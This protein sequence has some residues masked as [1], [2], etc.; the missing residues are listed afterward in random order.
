MHTD[1]TWYLAIVEF[2][3]GQWAAAGLHADE[4]RTIGIQYGPD[5]PGYALPGALI[6]LHRG[7]FGVARQL[8]QQAMSMAGEQVLPSHQAILAVSELWTGNLDSALDQFLD[9]ERKADVRGFDEPFFRWWRAD[10]VEGLLQAGRIDAA[11]ALVADWEAVAARVG[12]ERVLAHAIRCR[13]L[14][15]AARGDLVDAAALLEEAVDRQ[16]TADDPFGRGRVLLALGVVRRRTRQKRTARAAL[17]AALAQFESLGAAS[18]AMT[19]RAELARVGGRERIEGLSPSELRV[20]ELVAEGR[21]NRE[22]ASALFLGERTVASHLTHIYAKLGIRSRTEL[23][24][25]MLPSAD[26]SHGPG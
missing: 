14:I 12:R 10:Y 20:A 13:G 22:I 4:A 25:E 9:A 5:Q 8:S 3:S 23:A 15:A 26:P 2:W 11:S 1:L 18:W 7:Q 24:R 16:E 17:D 6:A 19:A 21:T